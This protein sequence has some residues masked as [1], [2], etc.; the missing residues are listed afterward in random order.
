MAIVKPSKARDNAVKTLEHYFSC[1]GNRLDLQ[2]TET[3]RQ[4]MQ[5]LVD[6]IILAASAEAVQRIRS[7]L[8]LRQFTYPSGESAGETPER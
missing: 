3:Q 1:L 7:E 5:L 6:N 4:D 2:W 8:N